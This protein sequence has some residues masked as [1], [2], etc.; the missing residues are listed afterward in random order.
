MYRKGNR[1]DEIAKTV[2]DIYI[3]YNIKS[4][5]IEPKDVCRKLGVAMIAYSEYN[6]EQRNL[7]KKKSKDG[8]FVKGSSDMPPTIFYNDMQQSKGRVRFTIFHELKHYVCEDNND[9]EDDLADYFA[10]YFM[11]P[12]PYLLLKNI[13]TPQEIMSYCETSQSVAYNV[14]SNIINRRKKYK[15]KLFDYEIK[16][17]E[18]LNPVLVEVYH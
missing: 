8:F 7:L 1:Y 2:I 11:C 16:L 14:Q 17:I 3:D 12:I 9:N 10:K 4:F 5:P 13:D 6:N 18:H 15:Y